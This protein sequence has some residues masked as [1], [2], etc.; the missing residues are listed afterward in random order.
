MELKN[1]LSSIW[2]LS[3]KWKLISLGRGFYHVI[4]SSSAE[5]TT[6]W[7]RGSISLKPGILRLQHW[8]LDFDPDEQKS[9]NTQLWVRFYKLPWEYWHPHILTSIAS[10]LGVPLKIDNATINGEFGHY[11]RVLIDV[12]LSS[13]LPENLL[14]ERIGKIFFIDIVYENMPSF[15]NLCSNIGHVPHNC[16]L[17]RQRNDAQTQP[18]KP[19]TVIC[20]PRQEEPK[21]I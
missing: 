6:I 5:K 1:K 7:G 19:K 10:G 4:L 14:I 18:H 2:G 8:T 20:P 13:K 9:S 11:A 16:S 15:C 12:D 21:K 17:G 3:S